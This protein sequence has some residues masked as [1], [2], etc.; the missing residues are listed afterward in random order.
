MGFADDSLGKYRLG[1]TIGEGT[2]AK[3]KLATD[4]ETGRT[5]AVKI[6][7]RETVINNNL[8]YQVKREISAM[9]ILDH[10]NI[11]K[12]YEVTIRY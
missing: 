5:A 3:V 1:R 6:I 10:P 7:H 4:A 8:A 2:F 11:V 9:R 12:I